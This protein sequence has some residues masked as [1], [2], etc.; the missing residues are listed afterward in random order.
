MSIPN[1]F[2]I[3]QFLDNPDIRKLLNEAKTPEE[4]ENIFKSRIGFNLQ[5]PQQVFDYVKA[6]LADPDVAAHPDEKLHI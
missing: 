6:V 5:D 2:L 3:D 4:A 1:K